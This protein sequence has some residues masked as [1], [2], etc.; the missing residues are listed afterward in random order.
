MQA[1]DA[2]G[3]SSALI[4]FACIGQQLHA[5]RGGRYSLTKENRAQIIRHSEALQQLATNLELSGSA[6]AARQLVDLV[7]GITIEQAA[8]LDPDAIHSV[9]S[10]LDH[11]NRSIVSELK[12]RKILILSVKEQLILKPGDPLF[13]MEVFK[14]FP[15][16]DYDIEE[17]GACLAFGRNTATVF[18]LMRALEVGLKVLASNL[19]IEEKNNWGSY[20]HEIEKELLNR[21]SKSKARSNDEEFYSVCAANFE[22]IKRAWRN[23]TMHIEK[24]YASDVAEEIFMVVKSFMRF[25]STKIS[26][27]YP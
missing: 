13:G 9:Q 11:M 26:E 7:S 19:N 4:F 27:Q 3:L 1:F 22:F 5:A 23:P 2:H 17:A 21:V 6:E 25:L 12:T 10:S 8:D 20:L 24:S 18:H 15:S 16:A 14:A